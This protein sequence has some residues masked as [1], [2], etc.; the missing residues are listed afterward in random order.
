[1]KEYFFTSQVIV[2]GLFRSL[3]SYSGNR[4]DANRIFRDL[5]SDTGLHDTTVR[6]CA[7]RDLNHYLTDEDHP[8][9]VTYLNVK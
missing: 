7:Y 3:C 4:S 6:V 1:M 9:R 2:D 5:C 8:V